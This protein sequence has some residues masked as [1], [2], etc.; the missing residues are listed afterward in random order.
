VQSQPEY[1]RGTRTRP[2]ARTIRTAAQRPDRFKGESKGTI[3][4]GHRSFV[5]VRRRPYLYL[6]RYLCPSGSEEKILPVGAEMFGHGCADMRRYHRKIKKK[7]HS[8]ASSIIV[9]IHLL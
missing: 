3:A 4:L 5:K 6:T 7:Q 8:N 1:D 9:V 2:A